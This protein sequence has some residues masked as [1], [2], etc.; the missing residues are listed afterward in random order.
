MTRP[1]GF[2][3][4]R[5]ACTLTSGTVAHTTRGVRNATAFIEATSFQ[6]FSCNLIRIGGLVDHT[7]TPWA[8]GM[9]DVHVPL[10]CVYGV[11]G[12]EFG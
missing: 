10:P 12:G 5:R 8:N 7:P 4:S 2:R 6:S 9:V 3:P 1:S 11:L